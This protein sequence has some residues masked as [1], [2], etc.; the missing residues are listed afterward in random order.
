MEVTAEVFNTIYRNGRLFRRSCGAATF[1]NH[2][3]TEM[4]RESSSSVTAL[5]RMFERAS[6]PHGCAIRTHSLAGHRILRLTRS[7]APSWARLPQKI[8]LP[9]VEIS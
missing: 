4:V 3:L 2:E 1:L 8:T 9:S 5:Y 6:L 7:F